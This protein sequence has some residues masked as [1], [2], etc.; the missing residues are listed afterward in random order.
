[1][2]ELVHIDNLCN[3]CGH[4][5]GNTSMFSGYGCNHPDCDDGDFCQ[6]KKGEFVG[7]EIRPVDFLA[8]AMT[9]RKIKCNRRLAKK[10]IKK[11]SRILNTNHVECYGLRFLGSCYG[12]ACPLGYTAEEEDFIRFGENP[13]CMT[14][15]EW[16]V[17]ENKK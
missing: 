17:V 16:L 9:R 7:I 4:F 3:K 2:E 6:I 5:V 11:A 8:M 13:D 14:K 12:L 1:M 15:G 10:F